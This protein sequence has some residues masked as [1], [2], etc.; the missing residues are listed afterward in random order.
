LSGE[1]GSLLPLKAFPVRVENFPVPRVGNFT[2]NALRMLGFSAEQ[3]IESTEIP[4]IFPHIWEF[5][6]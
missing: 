6:C 1:G 5:D 2:R 4:C 3:R